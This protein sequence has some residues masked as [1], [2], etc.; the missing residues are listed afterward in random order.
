MENTADSADHHHPGGSTTSPWSPSSPPS[1]SSFKGSG[2]LWI[3]EAWKTKSPLGLA[4]HVCHVCRRVDE[5][6][7]SFSIHIRCIYMYKYIYIIHLSWKKIWEHI[8]FI[9][10]KYRMGIVFRIHWIK[11][12]ATF[13]A[14][15][16][17]TCK[18]QLRELP[19]PTWPTA[20]ASASSN[21]RPMAN[22]LVLLSELIWAKDG[23]LVGKKR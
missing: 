20:S 6:I 16:W 9:P 15:F 23:K 19:I 22:E 4:C 2:L 17:A 12:I 11:W 3:S 14:L 8:H 5:Y 18:Y 7:L 10:W 13:R 21:R 1:Q